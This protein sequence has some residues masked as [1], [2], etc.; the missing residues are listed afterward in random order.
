MVAYQPVVVGKVRLAFAEEEGPAEGDGLDAGDGYEN[1]T[2]K[3]R[4][5]RRAN[6]SIVG[7]TTASGPWHWRQG[8]VRAGYDQIM[9]SCPGP[10]EETIN[11]LLSRVVRGRTHASC[12]LKVVQMAFSVDRKDL[13]N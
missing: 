11:L 2:R 10:L 8:G 5:R 3:V 9:C 4:R 6:H 7:Q 12:S 1:G 13:Q